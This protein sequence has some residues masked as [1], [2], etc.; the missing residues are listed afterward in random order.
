MSDTKEKAI[1]TKTII[2][3]LLN[4]TEDFSTMESKHPKLSIIY[5]KVLQSTTD[6]IKVCQ[7]RQI[8]TELHNAR[9]FIRSTAAT[10]TD[11]GSRHPLNTHF[12]QIVRVVS[13]KTYYNS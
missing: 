5:S 13:Y 8:T 12:D 10:V 7:K 9:H 6:Q 2:S 11:G 4:K 1:Q 3:H